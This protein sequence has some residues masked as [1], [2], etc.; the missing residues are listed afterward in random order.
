[1]QMFQLVEDVEQYPT[2]LSAC[3]DARVISRDAGITVAELVLEKAGLEQ[4]FTTRNINRPGESI[5]LELER[6]PFSF[7]Q[8]RWTFE[9]LAEDSCRVSFVLE[10]EM[11]RQLMQKLIASMVA[12]TANRLVDA[13]CQRAHQLYG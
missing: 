8:G 3:R 9:S 11:K 2:F 10:F 12:E 4:R 1:M 13:I 7:L 6:G 5:D